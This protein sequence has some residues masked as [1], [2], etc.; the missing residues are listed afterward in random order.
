MHA[1][2]S[3]AVPSAERASEA[4][5]NAKD[6]RDDRLFG[7]VLKGCALLVLLALVGAA[8]ST[9]WLG[10]DAFHT[11]GF[12]FLTS[13]AWD[14]SNDQYG[15]LVPIMGT[16]GTAFIA[17]LFAVPVSFGIALFL[18][19]IAPQWLRGPVSSAIELLAGI[20]SI[21]Y[22]MWG[23]FIFA[24]FVAEHVKPWLMNNF[25]ADPPDGQ[26]SWIVQHVPWVAKFF[27]SEYPFFGAGVFTAGLVLAVMIIPFISSVMRE[28]FQTVPTRLKESAYALGSSTWEV[29]WDIVVPYTRTAVIG[30]IFLGLGRALGETMA[31]AFVLGNTFKFSWSLLET[32]S[33]IASTIANQFGEAQGLQRSA[34]M[35]LAFLLFVVTFIVLLIARLMLRRL[36]T[37]EGK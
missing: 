34:L 30:G 35:A 12:G 31:V 14:P 10:M 36:A 25:S 37:K 33:S 3:T 13:A 20:P 28:V 16:V 2:V 24:P 9:L 32:G 15:A 4:A 27:A 7:W 5:R 29:V 21:I 23:L 19:E 26:V 11:F 17:L 1:T 18:T 8:G 22:G 6:S